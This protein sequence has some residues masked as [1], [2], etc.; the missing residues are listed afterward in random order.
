[1]DTGDLGLP[2]GPDEI[3]E[4]KLT[5]GD[6]SDSQS[7]RYDLIVGPVTHQAT[8]FGVVKTANYNQFKPRCDMR[9]EIFI[10]SAAH[11]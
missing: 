2:P 4:L 1:M 11:R 5:V 6:W 7:E 9:T 10:P 8:Q 3:C